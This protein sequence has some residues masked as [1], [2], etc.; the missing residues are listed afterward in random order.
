MPRAKQAFS[1][2]LVFSLVFFLPFSSNLAASQMKEGC[3]SMLLGLD[4]LFGS[5]GPR[6]MCGPGLLCLA[7]CKSS[8]E[9]A[10]CICTFNP[11]TSS[12]FIIPWA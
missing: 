8:L 10:F 9:G 1:F 5:Q 7:G 6:E 3:D 11:L 2:C 12:K 4:A